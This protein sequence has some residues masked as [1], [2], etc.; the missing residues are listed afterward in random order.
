MIKIDV[1]IP[2]HNESAVIERTLQ[3]VQSALDFGHKTYSF[4]S[5]I[6][7]GGNGCT[8]DTV[9]KSKK[10]A[11][12]VHDW[13][14]LGK[15][16][17]LARLNETSLADYIIFI[18]AGAT[19]PVQLLGKNFWQ[20]LTNPNVMGLTFFYKPSQMTVVEKIYW[21]IES[22]AKKIEML[23]GGLIAVSGITM[24]FHRPSS[25]KSFDFLAKEFPEIRWLNDDVVLPLTMRL[26]EPQR[27]IHFLTSAGIGDLGYGK[28][29]SEANRRLRMM[30]G[31]IQ[32]IR[33]LLPK[34]LTFKN[35]TAPRIKVVLILTRRLLKVFWAYFF[36]GLLALTIPKVLAFLLFLIIGLL[37]FRNQRGGRVLASL[38]ASLRAPFD[39]LFWKNNSHWN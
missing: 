21:Q 31:N 30:R 15:W 28:A 39:L 33:L 16:K 25:Q 5:Q 13:P 7:V 6:I 29:S 10:Y 14:A 3:S 2:A 32:W 22:Y 9:E 27:S 24:V 37:L 17:T 34:F 35:L 23:L 20:T 36:I 19:W 4:K 11:D 1:C 8:D 12:V 26:L 18:D 38:V